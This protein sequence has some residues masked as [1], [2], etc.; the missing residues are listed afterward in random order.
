MAPLQGTGLQA[1]QF[2]F[3]L[4]PCYQFQSIEFE[5]VAT[6]EEIPEVIDL[7]STVL[8]KLMEITPEQSKNQPQPT[9][10][11]ASDS[12]KEILRKYNIPFTLKTTA[13]EA[14]K[15]ISESLEKQKASK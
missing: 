5:V 2:V 3:K 1:K 4:K 11:L 7:Y 12:Q 9:V 14:Q 8:N 13:A 10:K 15:L 6:K